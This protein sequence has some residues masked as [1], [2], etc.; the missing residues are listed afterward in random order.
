MNASVNVEEK[1]KHR[2]ELI[3]DNKKKYGLIKIL[4]DC[5]SELN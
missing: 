5:Y 4:E 1:R 3:N 2:E